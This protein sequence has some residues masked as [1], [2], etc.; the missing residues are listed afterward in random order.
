MKNEIPFLA[1]RSK[2]YSSIRATS[3]PPGVRSRG[4]S[5][6]DGMYNSTRKQRVILCD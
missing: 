2:S 5:I 6:P 3:E 4:S 1:S